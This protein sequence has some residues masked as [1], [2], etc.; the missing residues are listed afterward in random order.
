MHLPDP[1]IG[2]ATLL[3]DLCIANSRAVI[4]CTSLLA[5]HESTWSRVGH[6]GQALWSALRAILDDPSAWADHVL[7]V[8]Y[9]FLQTHSY[10][11]YGTCLS[12]FLGPIILLVPFLIFQELSIL[13]ILHTRS[14]AHGWYCSWPLEGTDYDTLC[15]SWMES[16]EKVFASV[17]ACSET[18]NEWTTKHPI[19]MVIRVLAGLLGVYTVSRVWCGWGPL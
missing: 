12:L 7:V 19:L 9:S 14:L 10:L 4:K 11:I 15:E 13:V 18:F 16:R 1:E 5:S 17:D 2:N 6:L 3:E 8:F